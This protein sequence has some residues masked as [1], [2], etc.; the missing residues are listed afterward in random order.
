MESTHKA[1]EK[2]EEVFKFLLGTPLDDVKWKKIWKSFWFLTSCNDIFFFSA[3][4][5]RFLIFKNL[6]E[7]P[8][9]ALLDRNFCCLFFRLV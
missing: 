2:V 7:G 9:T 5:M 6:T 4:E 3:I 8:L 1:T